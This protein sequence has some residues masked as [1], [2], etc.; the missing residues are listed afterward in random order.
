MLLPRSRVK[1]CSARSVTLPARSSDEGTPVRRK[2]TRPFSATTA[3]ALTRPL[4]R[5]APPNM[6]T[7]PP[8]ATSV[9]TFSASFSGA[10]ISTR[11]RGLARSTSSTD[12]PAASRISPP[13]VLIRPWF[14]TRGATR[15]T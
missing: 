15:N 13:G 6:L 4:L 8:V 14:S 11:M 2:N 5:T 10:A 1:L 7:R 9:P 12:L 3:F